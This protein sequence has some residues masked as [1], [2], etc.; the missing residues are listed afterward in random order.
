MKTMKR[1]EFLAAALAGGAMMPGSITPA[2]NV[3]PSRLMRSEEAADSRVEIL[4]NEMIGQISPNIYSHFVEH[5]GGVVYDGIWVGEDSRVPNVGGIRKEL[6]DHMRRIRASVIRWPGGCFADSY[7]WRDGIGP[8]A[9]R[10]RHTNFWRDDRGARGSAAYKQLDSGP[11]KYEPNWFGTNEFMRF[12]KQ[13]GAQPYFAANLRSLPAK[14]FYEWVEYC[15]APAGATT[16]SDLRAAAGDREPFNVAFW[17]IG[18]ESWGCGGRFTPEEYSQEFRRFIAWAPRYGVELKYIGAGPNGGDINWTRGFFTSMLAKGANQLN[19]LYGWALHYYA[20]TTGGGN[21]FEYTNDEWYELLARSDRMHSLIEQHWAVMGEADPQ[22][23]VK[24]V[25][26][27][28]GAWHSQDASLPAGYLFGYPGALRDALI[29]GLTLDTF[30]RHA[31]KVVMANVAQLINT[32]HSLFVACEDKFVA[33]PNFHVFEMY[34]AHQGG[35]SVRTIFSAPTLGFKRATPN[36]PPGAA[37]QMSP[38]QRANLAAQAQAPATLWGLQGSASLSG[39]L[40][41]LTVVNPHVTEARET[42]IAVRGAKVQS[43]R[44]T[45]LASS[46]IH[47]HNSFENPQALMPSNATVEVQGGALTYRF[48]AASV[49]RLQLTLA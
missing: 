30:N 23:R 28:W 29:S 48:P 16:L 25:V 11:Q 10:P 12:C 5:L 21:A 13:T 39:K 33:T 7:N 44:A 47:A 31:D 15:N 14:D 27:E 40:L 4:L 32:I 45:T 35:Q 41:T 2:L 19:S 8:R 49:T 3:G 26:D 22:H 17:G 46:D 24:L 38:Q 34:A 6:V 42:E 43:G 18:N 9:Q 37:A 1:R 20:G 36:I